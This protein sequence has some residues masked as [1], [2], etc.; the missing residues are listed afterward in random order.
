MDKVDML[1][2]DGLYFV[3]SE[4]AFALLRNFEYCV[5]GYVVFKV[6]CGLE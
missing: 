1:L 5:Y 2:F 4:T 6:C 3:L